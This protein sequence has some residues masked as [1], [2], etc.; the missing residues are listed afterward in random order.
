MGIN[1]RFEFEKGVNVHEMGL[2]LEIAAIF[3]EIRA[4]SRLSSPPIDTW[5]VPNTGLN[6]FTSQIS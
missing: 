3:A 5:I 1:G 2:I 4:K 6:S